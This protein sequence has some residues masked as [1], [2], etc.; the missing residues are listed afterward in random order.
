[1]N[2]AFNASEQEGEL[3]HL[4]LLS[5]VIAGESTRSFLKKKK[6]DTLV[7]SLQRDT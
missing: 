2:D 6:K 3:A 4:K 1:M 7:F 5:E